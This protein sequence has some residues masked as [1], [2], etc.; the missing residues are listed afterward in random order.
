MSDLRTVFEGGF[1]DLV[2]LGPSLDEDDGLETAVVL[3]LFTDGRANDDDV[4]P[5]EANAGSDRRRGWWG[6]TYADVRGDRIGS[7]LWLLAR[8][9]QTQQVLERAREYGREALQWLV[10][11]GIAREVTVTAEIVRDG[12]LGLL[13]EVVRSA[14][15]V[16]RYRFERFWKGV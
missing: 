10:D 14:R 15:P 5:D 3:S 2:V 8:E 16:A 7:R 4:L 12:V 11:D 9:K 6:D 13:I 1:G